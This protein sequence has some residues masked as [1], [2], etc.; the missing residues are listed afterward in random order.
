MRRRPASDHLVLQHEAWRKA[1][2]T[3]FVG[4]Q[5]DVSNSVSAELVVRQVRVDR[6]RT[7]RRTRGPV[8]E[9]GTHPFL[10]FTNARGGYCASPQFQEWIVSES[11]Q[12]SAVLKERRS[13]RKECRLARRSG[14]DDG[15]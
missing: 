10:G 5:L 9:E 3:M 6:S 4:D 11:L 7:R 15:K 1:L 2:Q 12:V 14:R 13:S 8:G